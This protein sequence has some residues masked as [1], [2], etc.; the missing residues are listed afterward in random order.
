MEYNQY[1]LTDYKEYFKEKDVKIEIP[2]QIVHIGVGAL[3]DHPKVRKIT[4]HE[5][6]RK[7]DSE[8]FMGCSNLES[9]KIY[10]ESLITIPKRCFQ[11]CISLRKFVIPE[12]VSI[13]KR[14]AFRNCSSIKHIV[15]PDTVNYI[16]GGAFDKWTS[17]QTIEMYRDFRFG[18]ACKATII[19]N[20]ESEEQEEQVLTT[21]SGKFMYAVTCRCGHVGQHRYM[22]ITFPVVA[23]SK[24]EASEV[25]R[26]I[27]RVKHDHKYAILDNRQINQRE[28]KEL[29]RINNE[30]PYLNIRSSY[31]ENAEIKKMYD[32][33]CVLEEDYKRRT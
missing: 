19:R 4:I 31:Q 2:K 33:R 16:E 8:A 21:V 24:K 3:K 27:P 13:I 11:D 22:P 14:D 28:F 5:G 6:V 9:V 7:I 25:A 23:L 29:I 12:S 30:D 10:G 1:V 26:H 32:E 18:L 15:I 20:L 17:D